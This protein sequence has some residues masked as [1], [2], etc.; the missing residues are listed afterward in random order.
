MFIGVMR[1]QAARATSPVTI[2][3]AKNSRHM[4]M[5]IADTHVRSFY[6]SAIKRSEFWNTLLRLD[7]VMTLDDG[8]GRDKV[9]CLVGCLVGRDH[10][11]DD[12]DIGDVKYNWILS[13]LERALEDSAMS[14]ERV[15]GAVTIDGNYRQPGRRVRDRHAYIAN[16]AVCSTD[17]DVLRRLLLLLLTS[18][19]K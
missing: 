10:D 3:S 14:R 13:V 17:L 6:G 7:R 19:H 18:Y 5:A 4:Y 16:L 2:S 11:D 1:A 15:V 12:D 8:R 9:D